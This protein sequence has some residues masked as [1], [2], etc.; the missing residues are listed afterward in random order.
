MDWWALEGR[1][2]LHNNELYT[3][4]IWT[5]KR[6]KKVKSLCI[7]SFMH[8]LYQVTAPLL[9]TYTLIAWDKEVVE[10]NTPPVSSCNSIQI[11]AK[12]DKVREEALEICEQGHFKFWLDATL[13]LKDLVHVQDTRSVAIFMGSIYDEFLRDDQS[14]QPSN[15]PI[16]ISPRNPMQKTMNK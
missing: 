13:L 11:C 1:W 12:E 9:Y 14:R 10:R 6:P 16:I 4:F 8:S 15:N 2:K 7:H 3:K 5:Q